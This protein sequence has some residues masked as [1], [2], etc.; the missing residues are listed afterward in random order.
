M[1]TFD[2][3]FREMMSDLPQTATFV[4]GKSETFTI[5]ASV[6]EISTDDANSR[7]GEINMDECEIIVSCRDLAKP[8]PAGSVVIINGKRFATSTTT[9]T[10]GD[11]CL[12]IRCGSAGGA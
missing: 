8:P 9:N 11:E 2:A 1:S 3:D 7:D 6:S 4:I 10:P 5:P 12:R